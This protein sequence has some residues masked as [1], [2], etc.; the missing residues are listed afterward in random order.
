MDFFGK[1]VLDFSKRANFAEFVVLCTL[2]G[3]SERPGEG[4]GEL[5]YHSEQAPAVEN[6]EIGGAFFFFFMDDAVM[7]LLLESSCGI[8][9]ISKSVSTCM[10]LYEDICLRF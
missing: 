6:F 10:K 7:Y 1:H 4:L 3:I 2:S 8:S 9:N 5:S